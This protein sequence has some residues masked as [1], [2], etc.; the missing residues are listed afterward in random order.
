MLFQY[1]LMKS[2]LS[3]YRSTKYTRFHSLSYNFTYLTYI[4]PNEI[5]VKALMDYSSMYTGISESSGSVS[6]HHVSVF[7]NCMLSTV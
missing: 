1:G 3:S 7:L 2:N 4:V 5:I 6:Y